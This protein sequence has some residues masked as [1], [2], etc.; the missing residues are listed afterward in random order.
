MPK[1]GHPTKK[2]RWL[3]RRHAGFAQS[4]GCTNRNLYALAKFAAFPEHAFAVHL[5]VLK[6]AILVFT[7]DLSSNATAFQ[8]WPSQ[9]SPLILGSVSTCS[10]HGGVFWKICAWHE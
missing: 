6:I 1:G 9:F 3:S 8:I 4:E 5:I 7:M 2:G 10:D